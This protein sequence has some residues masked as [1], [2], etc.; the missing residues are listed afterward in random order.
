MDLDEVDLFKED[1]EVWQTLVHVCRRWRSIV[2][3]SPRRLNL[4]LIFTQGTPARHTL[5]VWPSFP[6][7]I[8]DRD[9]STEDVDDFVAVLKR[10]DRVVKV[11]HYIGNDSDLETVSG[12][13]QVPFPE[14]TDLQLHLIDGMESVL[15]DSFL[16]GSAP[17]LQFLW[18][19]RIPFPGLPNLLLSTTHLVTLRLWDIPHSGYFS[20][21]AMVSALSTLTSLEYLSLKFES[22]RSRPDWENR[23]LPPVTCSVLPVLTYFRF[24]GAAEYLEDL[25]TGINAPRLNS[26]YI[27]LFNQIVF[28]TPQFIR[29]INRSP[30]LEI[31]E[32]GIVVFEHHAASVDLCSSQTPGYGGFNMKIPCQELDWQVSSMEQVCTSCLPP[33]ST[34]EDL[35]I[36]EHPHSPPVW[37]DN[38]EDTLWVELLQPFTAVKNLYLSEKFASRI[39]PALQEL[40]VGRA[41]EVLPTL[42]NIF[43]EEI[44][45]SGTVQAGIQQFA[46]MRQVT[47]HSIKVS[48]WDDSKQDMRN[49]Y[50]HLFH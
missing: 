10:S 17:R 13:M 26:L 47:S 9:H 19:D 12:A 23:R 14:L 34:L 16:G 42:Q 50:R 40:T 35:Y 1:I 3:R 6:L 30:T 22:P 28:D 39:I 41:T 44:Q 25:V 18:L 31:F 38:I 2:F 32:R 43:L 27:T 33:L 49:N 15:S 21:E 45:P 29:F 8:R 37:Q 7:L 20:P 5:Y 24:R 36:Y 4:R 48:R 11:D 46:A